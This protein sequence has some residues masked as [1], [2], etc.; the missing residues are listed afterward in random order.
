MVDT[1]PCDAAIL[2]R[3][4]TVASKMDVA[5]PARGVDEVRAAMLAFVSRSFMVAT[6]EIDQH[7][8]LVNQG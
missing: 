4:M 8:S 6:E 7:R 1:R 5:P 3:T 2:G